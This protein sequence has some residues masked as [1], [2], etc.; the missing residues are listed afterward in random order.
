MEKTIN[1]LTQEEKTARFAMVLEGYRQAVDGM[2][3]KFR[4]SVLSMGYVAICDLYGFDFP[5]M[6]IHTAEVRR[7]WLDLSAEKSGNGEGKEKK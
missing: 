3:E 6:Q 5:V 4:Q 7:M 1:D 2:D